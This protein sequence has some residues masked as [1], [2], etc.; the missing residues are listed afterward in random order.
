MKNPGGIIKFRLKNGHLIFCVCV[1]VC[2]PYVNEVEFSWKWRHS[3]VIEGEGGKLEDG[4]FQGECN[5]NEGICDAIEAGSSRIRV[6]FGLD[7]VWSWI[8]GGEGISISEK[9]TDGQRD[10]LNGF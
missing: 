10:V 4:K 2:V 6:G 3:F 7:S 5:K 1:C 9:G 8:F